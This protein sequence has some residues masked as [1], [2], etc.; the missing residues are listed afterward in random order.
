[1]LPPTEYEATLRRLL[2]ELH[3]GRLE[4]EVRMAGAPPLSELVRVEKI[5]SEVGLE[6]ALQACHLEPAGWAD[7]LRLW[8]PALNA[9]EVHA[10]RQYWMSKLDVSADVHAILHPASPR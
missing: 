6:R 7:A 8:G 10:R 3:A 1:M 5:A 9:V 4:P 2:A